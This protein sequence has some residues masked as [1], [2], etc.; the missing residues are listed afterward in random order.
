FLGVDVAALVVHLAIAITLATFSLMFCR[1]RVVSTP[2]RPRLVR[3][4][5]E[6]L[7]AAGRG[8]GTWNA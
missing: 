3:V 1:W 5:P 7:T 8:Q 6:I 4:H 2:E